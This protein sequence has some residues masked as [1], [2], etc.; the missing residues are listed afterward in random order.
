M[1]SKKILAAVFFAV[2]LIFPVATLFLPKQ[3]FSE[4][5]NRSLASAPVLS[6]SSIFDKSFMD[7]TEK[8]LADHIFLREQIAKAK[9]AIDY[10]AGKREIGGV[11]ICENMLIE[12][13]AQPDKEITKGNAEAINAFAKKYAD[14]L[15]TTVMLVP[16]AEAIYPQELP[17]FAPRVGQTEYIRSFY[18]QLSDVNTVDAYTVLSAHQKEYIFYR[19]DHHW[20]S[21]GAYLGY[22]AL[23]KPLGFKAATSDMFNIEHVSHDFLGTLYSKALC[24]EKLADSIDLYTYSQGD[25]VTDVIRYS[26]KNKQTY[27]SIFFRENLEGKDK[28][29]VFLGQNNGLIQIKTNVANGKK[30]IVFKDSFANSVMQFLTLHYEK[31]AVVDLRYMNVPLSEYLDLSEYDQALF[32]YNVGT[33]TGDTSLKKVMAY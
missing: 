20:T 1:T 2:I 28:Y 26:G 33:F 3:S 16:T 23:S 8:Y 11:Y 32:L 7:Q 25:P 29:T 18:D 15:Q 21:Y 24:G 22:T 19:T 4:L 12:N 30:L 10:T 9:T 13:I 5:E 14:T 27:A 17:A 31:I 6:V